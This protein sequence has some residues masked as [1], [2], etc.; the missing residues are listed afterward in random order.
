[1]K[2]RIHLPLYALPFFVFGL[3]IMGKALHRWAS[4]TSPPETVLVEQVVKANEEVEPIPGRNQS[5]LSWRSN[6]FSLTKET[7]EETELPPVVSNLLLKGTVTGSSRTAVLVT[8]EDPSRSYLAK[9]GDV[10]F[11]E[12]IVSIETGRVILR[13]NG[14][15]ITLYQEEE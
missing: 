10:I 5:L 3:L 2:P 8:V 7:R 12:E 9:V 13:K 1:M 11:G 15:L 6:P 14:K 4:Y